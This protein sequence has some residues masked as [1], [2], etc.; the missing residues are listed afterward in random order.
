MEKTKM[1]LKTYDEARARIT[2]ISDEN[3]RIA[4]C[5]ALEA[6]WYSDVA[7]TALALGRDSL[8]HRDYYRA[9]GEKMKNILECHWKIV[10]KLCPGDNP[11]INSLLGFLSEAE[12]TLK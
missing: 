5:S 7:S 6:R 3:T 4:A 1:K 12:K 9:I 8:L 11:E 10:C 2:K